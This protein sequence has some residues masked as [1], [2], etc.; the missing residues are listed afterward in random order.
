MYKRIF[1]LMLMLICFCGCKSGDPHVRRSE[2]LKESERI[3][4]AQT[5][6][7]MTSLDETVDAAIEELRSAIERNKQ[8]T[9]SLESKFDSLKTQNAESVAELKSSVETSTGRHSDS[10]ERNAKSISSLQS[11]FETMTAQNAESMSGLKSTLE[12]SIRRSSNSVRQNTESISNLES[13]LNGFA[14]QNTQSIESLRADLERLEEGLSEVRLDVR[15]ELSKQQAEQAR[16]TGRLARE[17]ALLHD[18]LPGTSLSP[19]EYRPE[20]QSPAPCGLSEGA[21]VDGKGNVRGRY[22]AAFLPE[23]E[24]LAFLQDGPYQLLFVLLGL[25]VILSGPVV[26]ELYARKQRKLAFYPAKK[27]VKMI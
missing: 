26:A 7:A 13:T 15:R 17:A 25:A 19:A 20:D 22:N 18:S 24:E 10:I 21:P 2:M 12:Q 16:T 4:K 14:E 1:V 5:D 23:E 9:S 27:L 6:I 11:R 8:S 3:A